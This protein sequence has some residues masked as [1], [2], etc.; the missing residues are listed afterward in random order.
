[1]VVSCPGSNVTCVLS[2]LLVWADGTNPNVYVLALVIYA[3]V[4]AAM[5]R[6]VRRLPAWDVGNH[7]HCVAF[8]R[9][10]HHEGYVACAD[11]GGDRKALSAGLV[12][13]AF[14]HIF[15]HRTYGKGPE[16][17]KLLKHKMS[18]RSASSSDWKRR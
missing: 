10:A 6:E 16:R 1:M 13:P 5:I 9:R 11:S 3:L 15:W 4:W 12:G 17:C 18:A 7:S 14:R 2:L 8:L